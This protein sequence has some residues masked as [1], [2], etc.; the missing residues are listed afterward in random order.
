MSGLRVSFADGSNLSC[1]SS[2]AR[3]VIV[4]IQNV[5]AYY[6]RSA[7]LALL[8]GMHIDQVFTMLQVRQSPEH[9][10]ALCSARAREIAPTAAR[11]VHTNRLSN[12]NPK[13]P[14]ESS[15]LARSANRSA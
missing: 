6:M 9:S 1:P 11:M 7:R 13:E 3:L 14:T 10:S 8:A 5:A 4:E 12:Q 2:F 15:K